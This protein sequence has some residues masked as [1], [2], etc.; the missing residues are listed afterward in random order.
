MATKQEAL[1]PVELSWMQTELVTVLRG[2]V[3]AAQHAGGHGPRLIAQ[4]DDRALTLL[5][6]ATAKLRCRR[7]PALSPYAGHWWGPGRR[8][9]LPTGTA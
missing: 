8:G 5:A 1:S 6:L 3:R 4:R 7:Q 9:L 2:T